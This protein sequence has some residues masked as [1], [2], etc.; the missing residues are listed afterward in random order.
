[1]SQSLIVG[2]MNKLDHDGMCNFS[3]VRSEIVAKFAGSKGG[4]YFTQRF[5]QLPNEVFKTDVV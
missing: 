4:D 5:T 3:G 2:I 1:M